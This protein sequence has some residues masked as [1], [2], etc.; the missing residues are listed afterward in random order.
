MRGKEN[1]ET[2]VRTTQP[3]ENFTLAAPLLFSPPFFTTDVTGNL[4][5]FGELAFAV[6]MAGACG[7]ALLAAVAALAGASSVLGR[8]LDFWVCGDADE[9]AR[10][11][12]RG[13]VLAEEVL[14]A[15]SGE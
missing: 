3:N 13:S 1:E 9:A 10:L 15:G 5:F 6:L 12:W 4:P 2:A 7:A 8:L 14:A 11:A